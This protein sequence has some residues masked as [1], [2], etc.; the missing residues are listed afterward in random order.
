MFNNY[1]G[2]VNTL[3]IKTPQIFLLPGNIYRAIQRN[4]LNTIDIQAYATLRSVCSLDDLAMLFELNRKACIGTQRIS[5]IVTEVFYK[6]MAP[7]DEAE[8]FG[9][10][11]PLSATEEVAKAVADYMVGE[12]PLNILHYQLKS[13]GTTLIVVV[14]QGFMRDLLKPEATLAFL[15]DVIKTCEDISS[16]SKAASVHL[17]PLYL[18]CT[19]N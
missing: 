10:V 12:A 17:F 2:S 7:S 13:I 4:N 11:L 8:L 5:S 1:D 3:D 14:E 18:S 6:D 9:S 16:P 19:T 15:K